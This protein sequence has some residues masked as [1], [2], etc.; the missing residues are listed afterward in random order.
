MPNL[1]AEQ[2]GK[3]DYH[4]GGRENWSKGDQ[5][6]FEYHCLESDDSE[7]AALWHRSHQPVK[8][9]GVDPGTDY[10]KQDPSLATHP[11]RAAAGMPKNYHVEFGDGHKAIVFEDELLVHPKHFERPDP[12]RRS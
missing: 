5:A 1:N 10:G 12:P 11:Q 4:W 9:V 6:H 8:V 3:A 2:F 7:D